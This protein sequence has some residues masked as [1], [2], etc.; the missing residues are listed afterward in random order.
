M[1]GMTEIERLKELVKCA[2]QY[3]TEAI[4]NAE[5]AE[6]RARMASEYARQCREWAEEWAAKAEARRKEL[7]AEIATGKTNPAF[8]RKTST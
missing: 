2:E 4:R 1:Q 8:Y 6:E 5:E 3:Q 7:A